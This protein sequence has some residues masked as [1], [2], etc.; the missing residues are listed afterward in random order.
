MPKLQPD[1]LF[2]DEHL[3]LA[4][5]PPGLL[6]IPDRFAA[7]K[8]NL[9]ALLNQR[10]GK[11]WTVHRIDRETSGLICFARNEEARN[12]TTNAGETTMLP[13]S[14]FAATR[15]TRPTLT[16]KVLLTSGFTSACGVWHWVQ[17]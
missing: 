15:L 9:L 11:A 10:Y 2:E 6:S 3:I 13:T 12:P 5:K 8:P 17:T 14:G 7:E 1:I 16:Q 4:N